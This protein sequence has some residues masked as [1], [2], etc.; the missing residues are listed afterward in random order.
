MGLCFGGGDLQHYGINSNTS[1]NGFMKCTY[2]WVEVQEKTSPSKSN[3]PEKKSPSKTKNDSDEDFG[4]SSDGFAEDSERDE[5]KK[6]EFSTR[7]EF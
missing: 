2:K 6:E 1:A 3:S 5:N 7:V 4:D